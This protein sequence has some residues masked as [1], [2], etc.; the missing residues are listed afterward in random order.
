MTTQGAILEYEKQKKEGE[1]M[2]KMNIHRL[3]KQLYIAED[4]Y[5][6]NEGDLNFS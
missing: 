4:D 2:K 3:F 1:K 5:F 6:S